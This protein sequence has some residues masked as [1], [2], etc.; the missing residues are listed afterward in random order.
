[1][2]HVWATPEYGFKEVSENPDS[3]Y[4][5]KGGF[6]PTPPPGVYVW[7][8]DRCLAV[9]GGDS[10]MYLLVSPLRRRLFRDRHPAP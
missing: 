4:G 3:H 8:P 5:A 10:V 6:P 7:G 2:F 9:C 1:M